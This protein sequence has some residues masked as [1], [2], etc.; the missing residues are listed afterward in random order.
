MLYICQCY[1]LDYS[2]P[3]INWELNTVVS[4]AYP[5]ELCNML[6]DISSTFGFTQFNSPTRGN[7]ILDLFLTN[8]PGL[9]H[10]VNVSSGISDH[11]LIIVKSPLA[12]TLPRSQAHTIFLW[13]HADWQALNERLH[14]FS[15]HTD[16]SGDTPIQD[17]WNLFKQ[18]CHSCLSLILQRN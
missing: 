15:N 11:E 1:N 18:E 6:L 2:L 8:R 9:I 14:L 4:N 12:A 5:L 16:Y 17:L 10:E 3:N 13:Q 7:N